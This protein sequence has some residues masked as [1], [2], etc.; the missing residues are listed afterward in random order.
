MTFAFREG[1]NGRA[2][3]RV[4]GRT[5]CVRMG[6][7]RPAA[8]GPWRWA[9]GRTPLTSGPGGGNVEP[10]AHR[11]FG[12]WHGGIWHR[13]NRLREAGGTTRLW[14]D[15][16]KRPR[17]RSYDAWNRLVKVQDDDSGDPGATRAE[18]RYDG[19]HRRI[20]RIVPYGANWSRID[21]Y[22]TRSWQVIEE[23]QADNVITAN[24]ENVATTA[25]CQYVWGVRYVDDI[26][27]RDR[28]TD[29]DGECTDA[30]GS[31]RLFYL[32]DANFN[33]TALAAGATVVERY[34]Y[35]PYGQ[36][37]IYNSDW[38][39][40]VPWYNNRKNEILYCG[41]RFDWET[42]LYHVRYRMYHPTLGRWMQRNGSAD[43]DGTSPYE[44]GLSAPHRPEDTTDF[45]IPS[46]PMIDESGVEEWH[47]D[48]LP[49]E[50]ELGAAW[51]EITEGRMHVRIS[52]TRID[53][54]CTEEHENQHVRDSKSCCARAKKCVDRNG[55][56]AC[57]R[58]W[59]AWV[60]A[61]RGWS[62]CRAHGKSYSCCK[63]KKFWC[64][65]IDRRLWEV[66]C[67]GEREQRDKFCALS[68]GRKR[69]PFDNSGNIRTHVIIGELP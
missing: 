62:E 67:N 59:N 38:S 66:I 45:S 51:C 46:S 60:R 69:C 43:G 25:R 21:Y 9:S 58:R 68:Q 54:K 20:A 10:S 36:V 1:E 12:T 8:R 5:L 42:G 64:D 2:R 3:P 6:G 13:G 23:R 17:L 63:R 27:L 39:A 24:K 31:E 26:V 50:V 34:D 44:Y 22:Y 49:G 52:N 18:Y 14:P 35:D 16:A 4:A 28:D 65:Q 33:V 56:Q 32:T 55:R 37:T 29:S 48:L 47:D 40:T 30:G 7:R 57:L 19:L 15:A 11:S 53:R 41:Y 61:N